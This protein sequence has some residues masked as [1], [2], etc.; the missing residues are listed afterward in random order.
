VQTR[1]L[2]E[3]HVRSQSLTRPLATTQVPGGLRREGSIAGHG[4]QGLGTV[5][6][7][8]LAETIRHDHTLAGSCIRVAAGAAKVCVAE[9]IAVLGREA[10]IRQDG[11]EGKVPVRGV[12]IVH[13]E[14]FGHDAGVG[15]LGES[16]ANV[17]CCRIQLGL[18]IPRLAT[19]HG[20]P[21][22]RAL[23]IDVDRRHSLVVIDEADVK[24]N[25]CEL[26]LRN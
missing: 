24:R 15:A 19:I 9:R 6:L 21:N 7:E 11:G 20:D 4:L 17:Q 14:R 23:A 25:R 1:C 3:H 22:K 12:G 5:E 16:T 18:R 8:D 2:L 10:P 26:G 13:S